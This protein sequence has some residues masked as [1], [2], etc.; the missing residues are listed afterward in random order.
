MRTPIAF[1]T[2]IA[3]FLMLSSIPGLRAQYGPADGED[4]SA[5]DLDRVQAGQTAPD[6][7]LPKPAGEALTLS[8]LR[9]KNVVLVFYRGHW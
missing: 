8:S 7:T 9:D 6:F 5:F 4:L 3:I 1:A 2:T